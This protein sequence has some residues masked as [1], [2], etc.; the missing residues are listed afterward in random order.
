M[1][2]LIS[3]TLES[4][5]FASQACEPDD[6]RRKSYMIDPFERSTQRSELISADCVLP[7]VEAEVGVT[8]I[9]VDDMPELVVAVVLSCGF[10]I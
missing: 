10:M 2:S 4:F 8:G 7:A 9:G 5:D 3:F 1:L 6:S